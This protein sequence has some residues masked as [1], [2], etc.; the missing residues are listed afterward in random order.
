MREDRS[1]LT[2]ILLGIITL[3]IYPLFFWHGYAQDMNAVCAGDGRKTRGILARIVFSIL[4]LG[5]YDLFW[6]YNA[7]ERISINCYRRHITPT[8]NGGNILL[9]FILGSFILIGPFV[10]LYKIINGLNVLCMD[11]NRE[12]RSVYHT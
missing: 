8:T 1:L 7:G 11:Y 3:G 2:L 12:G 4:T 6:L 9:W 5:F 10:A